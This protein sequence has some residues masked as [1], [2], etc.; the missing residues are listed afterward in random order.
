LSNPELEKIEHEL[1]LINTNL[2]EANDIAT[3]AAFPTMPADL[4]NNSRTALKMLREKVMKR[5][6]T[7]A[8]I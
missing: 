3:I 4:D 6:R 7:R 1:N 5:A 2:A 8:N